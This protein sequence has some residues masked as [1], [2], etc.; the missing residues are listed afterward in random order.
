MD[1]VTRVPTAI[2]LLEYGGRHPV[3][4][5]DAKYTAASCAGRQPHADFDQVLAYCTTASLDRCWCTRRAAS[6]S[7]ARW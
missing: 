5:Y 7:T 1:W 2:D 6:P 4:V 3:T